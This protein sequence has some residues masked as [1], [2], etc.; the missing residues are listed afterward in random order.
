MSSDHSFWKTLIFNI[1]NIYPFQRNQSSTHMNLYHVDG[2]L[3][4]ICDT[5]LVIL[6]FHKL[7]LNLISTAFDLIK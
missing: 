2:I 6:L 1:K 4:I 5:A 7:N 3:H